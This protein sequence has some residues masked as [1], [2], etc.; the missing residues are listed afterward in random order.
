[1]SRTKLRRELLEIRAELD[2]LRDRVDRALEAHDSSLNDANSKLVVSGDLAVVTPIDPSE[3]IENLKLPRRALTCLHKA[4][5]VTVGQ[6][7]GLAYRDLWQMPNC[8]KTTVRDI[9]QAMHARGLMLKG[10]Y[11]D[12]GSKREPGA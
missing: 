11:F 2:R 7:T 1:M 12:I 8:F 6:L 5:I 3:P 4:G 10:E 9:E